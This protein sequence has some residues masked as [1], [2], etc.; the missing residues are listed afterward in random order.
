MYGNTRHIFGNFQNL[1]VKSKQSTISFAKFASKSLEIYLILNGFKRKVFGNAEQ[2]HGII[3]F[4]NFM[5]IN[6]VWCRP[7][8]A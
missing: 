4:V 2:M 7:T 6:S 1:Y 5:K 3:I 8:H